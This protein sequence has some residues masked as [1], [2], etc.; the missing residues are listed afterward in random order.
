MIQTTASGGFCGPRFLLSA[1]PPSAEGLASTWAP[2]MAPK[3]LLQVQASQP[4]MVI[5][6]TRRRGHHF[7]CYF[8]G[9][10]KT[11]PQ[12][13]PAGFLFHLIG[14]NWLTCPS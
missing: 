10:K 13:L 12:I 4:D 9:S 6:S 14:Q 1:L 11:F 7:P 8:F 5:F 3:W 2:L